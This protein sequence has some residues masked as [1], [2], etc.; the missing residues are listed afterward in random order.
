MNIFK[1]ILKVNAWYFILM[2]LLSQVGG[3]FNLS[4]I[5]YY[6]RPE[7][8]LNEPSAVVC[9]LFFYLIVS[10]N[11]VRTV[12]ELRLFNNYQLPASLL[13]KY[14]IALGTIVGLAVACLLFSMAVEYVGSLLTADFPVD[15]QIKVG[16]Y[17]SYIY[18]E[19]CH[20][21][22]L[23]FLIGVNMILASLIRNKAFCIGFS[24]GFGYAFHLTFI[25]MERVNIT[26]VQ[27]CLFA[28][29]GIVLL[30]IAYQI[31]KRWQ[32]ANSGLLMI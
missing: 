29:I 5:A 32:P 24:L 11:S 26:P 12:M 31:Y 23:I 2:I 8:A 13:H 10:Y 14:L 9:M 21:S 25:Y 18:R 19:T 4:L 6:N 17:I 30:I 28:V 7:L 27:C 20:F 22:F 16:G 15:K 3:Y 1:Q